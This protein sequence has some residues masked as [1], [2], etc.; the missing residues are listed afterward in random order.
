LNSQI[1]ALLLCG[2]NENG[3]DRQRGNSWP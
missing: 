3:L 2:A 1:C